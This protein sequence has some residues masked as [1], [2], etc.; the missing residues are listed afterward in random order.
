VGAIAVV[1]HLHGV[2][3]FG[4]RLQAENWDPLPILQR[5]DQDGNG[6][7]TA[8][9]VPAEMRAF[10][11]GIAR[12]TGQVG[13]TPIKL[14][15]VRDKWS[16][17]SAD[18]DAQTQ[19]AANVS[20][21]VATVRHARELIHLY[22]KNRDGRLQPGEWQRLSPAWIEEDLD[23]D[24]M[25]SP[26]EISAA[27]WQI[28]R[29]LP[30]AEAHDHQPHPR[31]PSPEVLALLTAAALVPESADPRAAARQM[32][33]EPSASSTSASSAKNRR[34]PDLPE[35]FES[36]DRNQ[37]GQVQMHEFS[38]NWDEATVRRF[39]DRDGNGDGVITPRE[40]LASEAR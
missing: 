5:L 18:S 33:S 27:L 23:E 32:A 8:A 37:D 25:L 29:P 24:G 12:Q 9:E 16:A 2:Y 4:D 17:R 13:S 40:W 39:R 36:A 21:P 3:F 28:E 11:D 1:W 19:P 31:T 15:A 35:A 20:T 34:R 30:E 22:D 10:V 6:Y 14:Q 38:D 26:I 7:V